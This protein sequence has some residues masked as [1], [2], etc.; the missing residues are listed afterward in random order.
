V[1]LYAVVPGFYAEIER[2]ADPTLA[3]RP[4]VVGGDPRKRGAVQSA[5]ADA[6]AAGVTLGMPV[7]DAL[8]L[9][10]RA[11]ALRTDMR[12]Y[13]DASAIL[14]ACFRSETERVEPCGL[15]AAWLD[16][17]GSDEGPEVIAARLQR[18]V[19]EGLGVS[20]GVGAAPVKFLARLAAERAGSEGFFQVAATEI[21]AFLDPLPVTSL[22]GVGQRTAT[23]LAALDVVR[24][25]DLRAVGRQALE[26]QLGNHGLGILDYAEGRDRSVLRAAP[27][28]RTLGQELT[29]PHEELD[30]ATLG[31]RLAELASGLELALRRE[32]LAAKRVVLKLRYADHETVT[33]SRT[34]VHPV[35]DAA[36]LREL[37]QALL[38]RTQA[39]ARPV[40]GLGLQAAALVRS[41]RDDRQLDLFGG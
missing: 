26:R 6:L 4:V 24:V 36:E 18:R 33:R 2:A 28:P 34:L 38:D 35:A 5:T 39:G 7:I 41:R 14:R 8:E 3:G 22:P 12:R 10:P 9:C 19:W 25:A 11:K 27:H 31:E 16:V 29:L 32:R 15:D 17:G 1:L 20:L 40:R 21:H 37:G 13:R 30:R 23:T